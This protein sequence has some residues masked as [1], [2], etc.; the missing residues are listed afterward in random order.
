MQPIFQISHLTKIYQTGQIATKAV[1]DISFD[2]MDQELVVII[3]DSGCGK[4]TTLNLIGG[5]DDASGGQ[6]YFKGE[7]IT[8]Y[9][10]KELSTYR[11]EHIGFIFQNYTLINNLTALENVLVVK[12]LKKN[13]LSADAMLEL[14]GLSEKKKNFPSLV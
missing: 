4:S 7:D 6:I 11:K 9:S 3:G 13:T 2:I 10:N 14:V 12:D 5:M 1:D 8:G